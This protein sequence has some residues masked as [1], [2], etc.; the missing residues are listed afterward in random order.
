MSELSP[1]D[2]GTSVNEHILR[3]VDA[4][5]SRLS[6]PGAIIHFTSL[7]TGAVTC[8]LGVEDVESGEPIRAQ[9]A[10]RVGS[11][12]KTMVATI[13]L[14]LSESADLPLDDE[15]RYFLPIASGVTVRRLLDM[16]SGIPDYTSEEFVEG[17]LVHPERLW[18][19]DELLELAFQAEPRFEP[20]TSWEYN[21][22]GY[23]LLGRVI[24]EAT[25]ASIEEL[26]R[27]LIFDP[28]EMYDSYLPANVPGLSALPDSRVRGYHRQ[29]AELVDATEINPSWA[30]T[31]GGAVSTV[32][33]L[34][35]YVQALVRGGL[36]QDATQ[37]E[38]LRARTVSSDLRYG[39]GIA[40]FA[41][42]W[43]HNGAL[44]GFQSFAGHDLES[45]TT[46]VVLTNL[47][48]GS[49]DALAAIVRSELATASHPS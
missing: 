8:A 4:E 30:W 6:I 36:L 43:G 35:I 34:S 44:P 47:D 48:D 5:R 19:P 40:D 2:A 18:T 10:M 22:A 46:L 27:R 39:I 28:L 42:M 38:R 9:S 33:D 26:A 25:G 31:A 15:V 45:D 13:A 14:K 3:A 23:I 49:A 41:G 17:L 29:G 32:R 1:L 24:E 7:R 11:I 20:G 16:T 12:T 37:A 21:N